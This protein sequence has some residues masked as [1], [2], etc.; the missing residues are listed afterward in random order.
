MV[1]N[2]E[3]YYTT[4]TNKTSKKPHVLI[5][6]CSNKLTEMHGHQANLGQGHL[7]VIT[8]SILNSLLTVHT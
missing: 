8:P 1:S 6:N 4:N 3:T 2:S 5:A 7:H